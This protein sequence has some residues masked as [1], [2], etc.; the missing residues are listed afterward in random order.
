MIRRRERALDNPRASE[1]SY[2]PR[3]TASSPARMISALYAPAATDRPI[4]PDWKGERFRFLPT[5]KY[6]KNRITNAGR[7]RKISTYIAEHHRRNRN[8]EILINA[9]NSPNPVANT[10]DQTNRLMETRAAS[11]IS[12]Q[13]RRIIDQSQL[14]ISSNRRHLCSE[15]TNDRF[16]ETRV[17]RSR[18]LHPQPEHF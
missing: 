11:L 16:S 1:A 2:C 8:L 18:S 13:H 17:E 6:A 14:A 10:R 7:P 5:Q 9:S 3:P 15:A 4:T 12:G